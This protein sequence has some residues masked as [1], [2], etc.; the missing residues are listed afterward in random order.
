MCMCIVS[1]H[2]NIIGNCVQSS[3][4]EAQEHIILPISVISAALFITVLTSTALLIITITVLKKG[5]TNKEVMQASIPPEST[6]EEID[7]MKQSPTLSISDNIA[8]CN[9]NITD[10]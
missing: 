8:Y 2:A 5:K 3:Q 7:N 9:I 6:Y 1:S 10:K 4:D